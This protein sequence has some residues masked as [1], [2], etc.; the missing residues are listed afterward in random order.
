MFGSIRAA[1]TR[2]LAVFDPESQDAND[3]AVH[4]HG[5]Q[6]NLVSNAECAGLRNDEATD[7]RRCV[8]V[9]AALALPEILAMRGRAEPI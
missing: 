2:D 4:H 5:A 1:D 9:D 3:G 6:H 8:C 7:G